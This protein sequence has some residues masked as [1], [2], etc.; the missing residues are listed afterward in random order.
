MTRDGLETIHKMSVANLDR[1]KF[2]LSRGICGI[3]EMLESHTKA[4]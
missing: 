1:S 4:F 2:V 3:T